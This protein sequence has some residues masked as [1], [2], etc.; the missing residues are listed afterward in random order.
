MPAQ[1]AKRQAVKDSR[2]WMHEYEKSIMPHGRAAATEADDS[3][4]DDVH[5]SKRQ[6]KEK[7][8][9]KEKKKK[10]SKKEHKKHKKVHLLPQP[11]LRTVV[12]SQYCWHHRVA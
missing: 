2:G 8:E 9:K 6:K 5:Q 11:S 4:S 1:T 7:K 3:D 10:K 12:C